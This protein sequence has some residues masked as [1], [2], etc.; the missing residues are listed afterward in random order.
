MLNIAESPEESELDDK[1]DSRRVALRADPLNSGLQNMMQSR[2][3]KKFDK[4]EARLDFLTENNLPSDGQ[5]SN[6]PSSFISPKTS[7]R[8]NKQETKVNTEKVT[9]RESRMEKSFMRSPED[10]NK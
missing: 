2:L 7:P 6:N 3:Q 8:L 1:S 9:R 5:S 4:E 10:S